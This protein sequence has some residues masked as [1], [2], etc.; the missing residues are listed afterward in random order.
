MNRATATR[1]DQL[2]RDP[3]LNLLLVLVVLVGYLIVR[4]PWVD[5]Q[6]ASQTTGLDWIMRPLLMPDQRS[7]DGSLTGAALLLQGLVCGMLLLLRGTALQLP[8]DIPTRAGALQQRAMSDLRLLIAI[9]LGLGLLLSPVVWVGESGDAEA[10]WQY[11]WPLQTALLCQA[12]TLT[13]WVTL[14]YAP[15][16][17]RLFQY[18]G[19]WLGMVTLSVLW[20]QQAL[21]E[22]GA[23]ADWLVPTIGLPLALGLACFLKWSHWQL[24][25][26]TESRLP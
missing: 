16:P 1:L 12:A 5:M 2:L 23:G 21:P 4:V 18:F 7:G 19:A 24:S 22:S 20:L 13:C 8:G 11:W 14:W 17:A 10:A 9:S 15:R 3:A 25:T 6:D 26:P